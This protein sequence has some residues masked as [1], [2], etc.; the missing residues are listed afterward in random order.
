MRKESLNYL[1]IFSCF[2][3]FFFDSTAADFNANE[4]KY[5]PLPHIVW[6]GEISNET[7]DSGSRSFL[8]SITEIIFGG[9]D[10]TILKP[11]SIVSF[12][13]DKICFIDQDKKAIFIYSEKTK[14]IELLIND[15]TLNSLIALCAYSDKLVFT[16]SGLNEVFIYDFESE[17][18]VT[19]NS[20]IKQPTG[21]IYLDELDE[22]WVCETGM[23]RI[24]RL[25]SS[26]K[27][28]GVI[29]ERG[30]DTLQFNFPT[31]I[32]KDRLG[33]V[34]INDSMN[35]RVQILSIDGN[36]VGSFGKNGNGS[37]DLSKPKG[38]ATD[39]FNNI[40]VVD[41]LFN[42][43]QVFDQSGNLL[44]FF[45]ERGSEPGKFL[46]PT[47]IFIDDENRIYVAD[48]FNSRIQVFKLE[49]G[50]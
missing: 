42:N 24:S 13:D 3:Q 6:I 29:G 20:S 21:I 4:N 9:D 22:F 18:T 1:I 44:C 47:G 23:H 37:G 5:C 25:N 14:E 28:I 16:D 40:Y 45:G 33:K 41:A 26:G 43:V 34:Y 50:D 39:T 10:L 31:F 2:I 49:C 15:A 27:V 38:I 35:F 19:L 36:F 30:A 46:L 8:N 11:F 48:S 17:L 12:P 7:I 32:W